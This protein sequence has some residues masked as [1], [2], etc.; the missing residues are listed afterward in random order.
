MERGWIEDQAARL[1]ARDP[2][3]VE[4]CIFALEFVGRLAAVG[5]DFVFKGGTSLLLHVR[6]PRRLSIDVDI[7]TPVDM[8]ELNRV[9]KEVCYPPFGEFVYQEWRD[10][11]TRQRVTLKYLTIHPRLV[12]HG[13]FNLMF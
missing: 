1:R 12:S 7:A 11:E 3:L 4:T 9:L 2:R 13:L 5:L 8:A 6:P 10:R